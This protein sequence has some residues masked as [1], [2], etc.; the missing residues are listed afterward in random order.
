MSHTPSDI[1]VVKSNIEETDLETLLTHYTK[2]QLVDIADH[3]RVETKKSWR[4]HKLVEEVADAIDEQSQSIYASLLEEVLSDIPDNKGQLF[5]FESMDAVEP[6]VP[7]IQRGFFFVSQIEE[8]I[9]LVIPD[10]ILENVKGA[11]ALN[12]NIESTK[13]DNKKVE[14][15]LKWKESQTAIYGGYSVEHLR[16]IWN[17]R[18]EDQLSIEEIGAILN[19]VER[20]H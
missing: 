2:P 1:T 16:D 19:E 5:L 20:D 8:G 7:L 17:K 15:L 4:K 9:A 12:E 6:L 10:E 13:Q 14:L 11:R 3:L 18:F